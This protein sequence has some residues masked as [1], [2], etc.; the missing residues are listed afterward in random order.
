MWANYLTDQKSFTG[1][2]FNIKLEEKPHKMSFKVLPV[3][4][5]K[6]QRDNRQGEINSAYLFILV[7]ETHFT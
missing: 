6:L 5:H 2:M 3:K 4:T 1:H 7:L